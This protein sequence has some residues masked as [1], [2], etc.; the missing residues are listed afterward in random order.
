MISRYVEQQETKDALCR[1]CSL[2]LKNQ[3]GASAER[4]RI[5]AWL[6][7]IHAGAHLTASQAANAIERGKHVLP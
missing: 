6:R 3:H 2:D 1:Q 5:V 7:E 4:A